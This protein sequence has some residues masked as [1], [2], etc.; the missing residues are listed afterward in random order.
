MSCFD[1]ALAS[2]PLWA[3]IGGGKAEEGKRQTCSATSCSS[4][5]PLTC[6]ACQ[7][8]HYCSRYCCQDQN[9]SFHD[10]Y[11]DTREHQRADWS[12]HK[13]SCAPFALRSSKTRGRHLVATRN[14]AQGDLVFQEP[15]LTAGVFQS[16]DIDPAFPQNKKGLAST[17]RQSALGVTDPPRCWGPGALSQIPQPTC[18][19]KQ[20]RRGT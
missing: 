1:P 8:A 5:A 15:P 2:S 18:S 7:A 12:E 9:D 17:Q 6:S 10:I 14:I 20:V 16:D 4:P 13:S 19:W 11:S 3:L